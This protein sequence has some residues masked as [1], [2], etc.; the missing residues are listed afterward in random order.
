M[1]ID[2]WRKEDGTEVDTDGDWTQFYM[3]MS[4]G[5][6]SC[7]WF[8]LYLVLVLS[9]HYLPNQIKVEKQINIP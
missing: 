7:Q 5:T 8:T 2:G 6:S 4:Q 9:F 1:F 3:S